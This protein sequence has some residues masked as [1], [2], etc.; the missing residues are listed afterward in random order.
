MD[1][2][3]TH[4]GVVAPLMRNNIDTD[5]IIP[6]VEMKRVSKKGLAA[7][8]FA[9]WRYRDRN[10][11]ELN[12]DFVLNQAAYR[13]A[14]ILLGGRNF[15][16]GSSREH[17]VWAL[18]EFG[19]RVLIAPSFGTI[20]SANCVANGLL[21][22]CLPESRVQELAD[23]VA[24]DPQEHR[25]EIDLPARTVRQSDGKQCVFDILDTDAE[26]LMRG[27]DPID[28]TL[29]LENEITA[30]ELT[31]REQRPWVKLTRIVD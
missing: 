10:T 30:F 6:S 9:A 7:G 14:S 25:L 2:F 27:L 3:L 19:I 24:A 28:M 12:P 29:Q 8:L 20:F 1:R 23:W 11:G 17:A 22:V 13:G 15:G 26:M 31:N 4:E 5:A 21:P 18:D 16:C